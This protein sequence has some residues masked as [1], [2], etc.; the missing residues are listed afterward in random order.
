MAG[1]N[2]YS[3]NSV[4]M[5]QNTPLNLPTDVGEVSTSFWRRLGEMAYFFFIVVCALFLATLGFIIEK[6]K[7]KTNN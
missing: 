7:H 2:G 6:L 5:L 1:L 4:E 3:A